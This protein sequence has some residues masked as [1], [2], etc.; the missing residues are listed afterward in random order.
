[1]RINLNLIIL[2]ILNP[3][4]TLKI[5][6]KDGFYKKQGSRAW[7][8]GHGAWGMGH[9]TWAERPNFFIPHSPFPIPRSL[10]F[11]TF[12]FLSNECLICDGV[13]R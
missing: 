2:L 6:L 5:S 8:M 1:M 3:T 12:D 13:R 4:L 11:V 7:G 9:G 10:F